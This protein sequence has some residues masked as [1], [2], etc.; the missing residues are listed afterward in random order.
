M[1]TEQDSG[2]KMDI[3]GRRQKI[4]FFS[5]NVIYVTYLKKNI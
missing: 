3:D 2:N 4:T 1:L 5:I